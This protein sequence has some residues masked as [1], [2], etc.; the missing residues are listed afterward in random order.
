MI[1]QEHCQK[2]LDFFRFCSRADKPQEDVIGV[3]TVLEAPIV[4]IIGVVSRH[5]LG[6]LPPL[7]CLRVFPLLS[8]TVGT[9]KQVKV[10]SI[11][12]P[13]FSL[14]VIWNECFSHICVQ[15]MEIDIR[16]DWAAN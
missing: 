13:A 14:G 5:G 2:P 11:F 7:L 9:C 6:L 12:P 3:A 8:E 4:G 15:P 1:A 10:G 16:Q